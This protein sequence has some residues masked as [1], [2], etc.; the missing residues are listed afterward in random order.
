MNSNRLMIVVIRIRE[1]RIDNGKGIFMQKA[2]T[3]ISYILLTLNI[4]MLCGGQILFKLGLEKLGGVNLSNAWKA[5][6]TLP[7][8]TGLVLYALATLIWFVVLSR[9][10][11]SV[12]YPIQSVAYVLGIGA[13]LI[14]FNEPVSLMKWIGAM[15][16]MIGVFFIALD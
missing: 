12:A 15:I 3:L 4:L 2:P 7:I 5:I 10:P 1:K 8:F 11:L 14:F 9:M 13:A 6:F 16:I